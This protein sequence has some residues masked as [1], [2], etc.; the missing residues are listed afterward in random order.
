MSTPQIPDRSD[1]VHVELSDGP[2]TENDLIRM[3]WLD[4]FGCMKDICDTLNSGG[5]LD[6]FYLPQGARLS[7]EKPSR[8]EHRI[9]YRVGGREYVLWLGIDLDV[10]QVLYRFDPC[11]FTFQRVIS[12][13]GQQAYFCNRDLAPHGENTMEEAA[14]SLL[15]E[16]LMLDD[17]L[18]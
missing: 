4:L 14:R 15:F 12:I 2:F 10:G 9:T 11:P 18:S 6:W 5:C 3:A 16:F 13:H 1:T 8:T 7:Y 17:L